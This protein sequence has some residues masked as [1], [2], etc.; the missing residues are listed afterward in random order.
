M[1]TESMWGFDGGGPDDWDSLEE[2]L[3]FVLD[4][5]GASEKWFAKYRVDYEV[6]WWCGHFQSCFDG[7]PVL[8]ARLLERLG[9]FGAELFI[10][11]YFSEPA[12]A[13]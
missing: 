11:N 6:I 13:E 3:T 1:F 7:G 2:G 9:A 4:Q 8:S 12:P 10:D 5:L